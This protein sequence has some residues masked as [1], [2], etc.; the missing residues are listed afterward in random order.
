MLVLVVLWL[1]LGAH[2]NELAR[3]LHKAL[4][5]SV[6]MYGSETMTRKE[7]ERPRIRAVL[8]D[9]LKDLLGIRIMDEAS[10][11]RIQ[12]L[13]GVIKG[14][15]ERTDEGILRR[16]AIW[17]KW[18]MI[19]PLRGCVWGCEQVIGQQVGGRIV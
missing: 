14:V 11:V 8:M 5:V 3:V 2:L 12:E 17:R 13:C 7:K 6:L 18:R 9:N 15:E 19:E 4:L 16:F 10:N 1:M